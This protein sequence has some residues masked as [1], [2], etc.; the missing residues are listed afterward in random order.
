MDSC[1]ECHN[2]IFLISAKD[3][4]L[5]IPHRNVTALEVQFIISVS[6]TITFSYIQQNSIKNWQVDI[7]VFTV[8]HG[9]HYKVK[10][11]Q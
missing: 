10:N 5:G 6:S 11:Y 7:Y 2:Y 4:K 8:V 1:T 9:S 3:A